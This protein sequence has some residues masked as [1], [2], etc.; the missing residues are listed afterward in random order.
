V[1]NIL[2]PNDSILCIERPHVPPFP[3]NP[4]TGGAL[5]TEI[6]LKNIKNNKITYKVVPINSNPFCGGHSQRADGSIGVFGGDKSLWNFVDGTSLDVD[7]HTGRRLYIPCTDSSCTAGSWFQDT[8]MTSGRWYPTV[9]TLYDGSQIIIGG[10]VGNIDMSKPEGNNPT[11]EYYP[12]KEGAWP[13]QLDLLSWC[14]PYCLYPTVMQLPSGNVMIMASN[15]TI[16]L[17]PADESI[18]F[19]IPDLIAPDHMP[20]VYPHT[21]S[22]VLLPLTIKNNY[23]ATL[24]MCGGSAI[25][26]PAA[27]TQ[28]WQ[29]NPDESSPVWKRIDDMPHG[30]VFYNLTQVMPDTIL[31][32]DGKILFVNGAGTG[33]AG[34]IILLT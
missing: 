15:K 33:I 6:S 10:I 16:I 31:L 20:W 4:N 11:Y 34:G 13:K 1:H 22:F 25:S 23:K 21:P 28:C 8:D 27:S 3:P 26:T 9:A 30:R 5:A 17:N 32:P 24:M 2:L 18:S 14:F 29:I 7:G 19:T 12:S